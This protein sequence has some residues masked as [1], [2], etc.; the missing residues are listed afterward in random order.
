VVAPET[1]TTLPPATGYVDV[2]GIELPHG[3]TDYPSSNSSTGASGA[4]TIAGKRQGFKSKGSLGDELGHTQPATTFVST[5]TVEKNLRAAA[6]A[7]C[8][9]RPLLLE[10]PPGCGKTALAERLAQFTGN[11][12]SMV[13]THQLF[14]VRL[15]AR[16]AM[17]FDLASQGLNSIGKCQFLMLLLGR[18]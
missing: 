16:A 13:G 17:S 15:L 4:G 11:A 3:G 1:P 2:A 5:P 6:L 14:C 9:G 8:A 7:L 12:H 10:G 18:H